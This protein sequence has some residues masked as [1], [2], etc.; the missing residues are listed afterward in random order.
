MAPITPPKQQGLATRSLIADADHTSGSGVASTISVSTTFRNPTPS[1]RAVLGSEFDPASPNP[2][3][4]SRYTQPTLTRTEKVLT[5]VI[6]APTLMYPSGIAASFAAL[7][8]YLPDTI[9]ITNGYHGVHT[10]IGVYQ[11]TRGDC[12]PVRVITLDDPYPRDGKLLVW[13]ETPLNPT[14]E[15]RSIEFY[16]KK[17]H[18]VGGKLAVDSTFGPPPLQDPFLWGADLVMHSGT[19]YFGGHSDALSGTLSV[20]SKDEW[21]NLWHNRTYTGSSVGSLEAWLILRSL[22]TL[23]LRVLRQSQTATALAQWLAALARTD[24]GDDID[25]PGGVVSHVWHTRLQDGDGTSFI[26]EGKQMTSGPACFAILLTK[27]IYATHLGHHTKI[28]IPATS[29][30]GV[31]SLIEQRVLSDVSSDPR[32]MRLSIGVEDFEDLKAD[33]VQGFRKVIQ[34]EKNTTKL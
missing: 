9:A 31:E 23:S 26:G 10:S 6:G 25:G 16:A 20:T 33:L 27:E 1:E 4:Y 5:S 22:R 8:H 30:G 32:L 28:F 29:L 2:D 24:F 34:I 21:L 11:K 3:V 18:A 12:A 19:K 15:S 17:A 14:G 7:L 13:V